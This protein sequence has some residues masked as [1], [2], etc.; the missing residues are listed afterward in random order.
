MLL[1]VGLLVCWSVALLLCCSAALC[2]S[3]LVCVA[4]LCAPVGVALLVGLLPLLHLL[5]HRGLDLGRVLRRHTAVFTQQQQQQQRP[6]EGRDGQTSPPRG[7]ARR[8]GWQIL[9]S[10]ESSALCCVCAVCVLC[11]CCVHGCVFA[12]CTAVCALRRLPDLHGVGDERLHEVRDLELVV[13][14]LPAQAR[15]VSLQLQ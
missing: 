13:R 1:S 4:L 14:G 12:V 5:P 2:W 6:M 7:S 3:V 9:Q 8:G 11:V 10:R 15:R